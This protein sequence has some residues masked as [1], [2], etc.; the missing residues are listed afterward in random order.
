MLKEIFSFWPI[1]RVATYFFFFML[2]FWGGK[3]RFG[4]GEFHDDYASLEVMKS[5]RG[6]AAIGVILHHIS[7]EEVFKQQ[8]VLTPFVNAGAFFVAIFFFC[9]GY[10]LIKSL[11]TKENYLKGF[12]KNRIVKSIILPFYINIILYGIY[13]FFIAGV[14]WPA[15]KWIFNFSGLTMMNTYAWFPIVL[16]ILYLVFFLCFRFIKK[17]PVCFFII[18][19]VIIGLGLLFCYNGHFAWWYGKKNW[20]LEWNKPN[21]IWWREQKVL[22]FSGEWWVN[23]AIGFLTGL[24]FANYEKKI[25]P[26][27]QKLYA[28]K[29]HILLLLTYLAFLLSEYGQAHFG[30]WTEWSTQGPGVYSKIRTYFCQVP[31]FALLGLLVIVFM[32][33]YHVV[34]PVTKFF[35]KYS[36][37]TYLMNLMALDTM[38]FLMNKKYFPFKAGK[39]NLLVFAIMVFIVSILLGMGEYHLTSAVKKLLFRKKK[40]PDS[41]SGDNSPEKPSEVTA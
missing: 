28:L 10:G 3:N 31:L 41:R 27:F 35:G 11:D 38:R 18:F 12:V 34:N 9:S 37:D 4:T 19:T 6:F 26:W 33:K 14:K 29:F 36:L 7:Q 22:W 32:M 23:S 17:R 39:Y 16:A 40:S 15:Q 5:L 24:L 20:W 2:L 25:V 21:R 13:A 8:K 1:F 30:Y